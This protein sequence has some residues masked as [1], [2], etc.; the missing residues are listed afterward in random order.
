MTKWFSKERLPATIAIGFVTGLL[1]GIFIPDIAL[2]IKV[3]GDIYIQ[4]LKMLIVPIMFLTVCSGILQLG[5][6]S[7]VGKMIG[8]TIFIFV[9]MF[10]LSSAIALTVAFIMRPGI[11]FPLAGADYNEQLPALSFSELILSV[12]PGNP[13]ADMANG[14]ILPSMIFAAF[15]SMATLALGDIAAPVKNGIEAL[16]AISFKLLDYVM[17]FSPFGV[18]SLIAYSTAQFGPLALGAIG[19]YIITCYIACIIVFLLIMFLPAITL[20]KISAKSYFK[21]LTKLWPVT[22]ATTSSAASLGIAMNVCKKDLELSEAVCDFVLP[23]GNTIN[24]LGGACSFSCLAIFAADA[25][26]VHL[27]FDQIVTLIIVATLI[28]MSAPGIPGGGIILGATFLIILGMPMVIMAP[29]AAV[30]RLLDMAFTTMNVTGD[31]TAAIL[32]NINAPKTE[33][34]VA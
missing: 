19:R 8:K 34:D 3:V 2:K 4:L 23:L 24:M 31:V 25:Y 32:L 20:G 7:S 13:I 30:Y 14:K 27:G 26:G 12:I 17:S 6:F 22:L 10:I 21:A 28:N 18:M 11:G 9:I 1:L 16:R 15:F 29:I 5:R 33:T